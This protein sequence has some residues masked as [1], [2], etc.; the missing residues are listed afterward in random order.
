MIKLIMRTPLK[1]QLI[2]LLSFMTVLNTSALA[3]DFACV[4][5][6]QKEKKALDCLELE[7]TPLQASAV[8]YGSKGVLK[9]YASFVTL[10]KTTHEELH[11]LAGDQTQLEASIA[12][13]WQEEDKEVFVLNEKGDILVFTDFLFGNVAPKRIVKN[14]EIHGATDLFVGGNSLVV[15]NSTTQRVLFLDKGANSRALPN[16]RKDQVQKVWDLPQEN[17]FIAITAKNDSEVYVLDDQG[18]IYKVTELGKTLL[19]SVAGA[20][21]LNYFSN[22]SGEFVKVRSGEESQEIELK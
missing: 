9:A 12:I 5:Q 17:K 22:D 6:A 4:K 3:A 15:L 10:K 8:H 1:T 16:Q 19:G 13:Y 11:I 20:I 21:D 18:H 2:T 7:S 14:K